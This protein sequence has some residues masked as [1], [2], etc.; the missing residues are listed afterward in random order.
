MSMAQ[1]IVVQAPDGAAMRDRVAALIGSSP[2]PIHLSSDPVVPDTWDN[3]VVLFLVTAGAFAEPA[4]RSFVEEVAAA[5]VPLLP[6]V[7]DLRTFDF[8]SVPREFGIIGERNAK[9]LQPDDGRSLLE[10][11]RESL[12]FESKNRLRKVFISYR[13]SDGEA[14]AKE[15]EEYLW[16]QRC[17]AFLDTIQIE[18]GAPVQEV[19]VQELRDKDFV[20]FV[21]SPDAAESRWIVEELNTALQLRIPVAVVRTDPPQ[22]YLTLLGP[23]AAV[24]WDPG[25]ARRVEKVFRLVSRGIGSRSTLDD[26]MERTLARM[27]QLRRFELRVRDQERR[28]YELV[29]PDRLIRIEYEDAGVTLERLHRLYRWYAEEPPCHRAIYVCGDHAVLPPTRNALSWASGSY[30]LDVRT[31]REVVELL[32]TL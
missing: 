13:R 21:D 20:L 22:Q 28:R 8:R 4:L 6:V 15:I 17:A 25:D 10:A 29:Q 19:I 32:Q 14:A 27:A 9:G 18:G 11:V 23:V 7:E 5:R 3:A 12:G 31:L 26:R 2:N 16:T 1:A 24:E 30:P